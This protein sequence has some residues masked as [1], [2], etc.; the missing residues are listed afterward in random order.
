MVQ[1][2]QSTEQSDTEHDV[3]NVES[4]VATGGAYEVIRKR[5]TDQGKQLNQLTRTLNESRLDEF[6]SSD[7][8]VVSRVRVRT[9]NNSVARDMVQVGDYLLFGY[10]VFLGLKKETK[11]EDVFSL[12]RLKNDG[13]NYELEP[14]ELASSFLSQASFVSDFDELYRYYKHTRLVQLTV[15]KW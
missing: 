12:F 14:A 5:L 13:G 7:M 15:H 2:D 4:A 1:Q 6:G 3:S 8:S 11:I 10:N 9:E